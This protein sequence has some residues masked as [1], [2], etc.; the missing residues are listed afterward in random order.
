MEGIV[1]C[2]LYSLSCKLEL[3]PKTFNFDH[4]IP[5]IFHWYSLLQHLYLHLPNLRFECPWEGLTDFNPAALMEVLSVYLLRPFFIIQ[6]W[7]MVF[8]VLSIRAIETLNHDS[9]LPLVL[10]KNTQLGHEIHANGRLVMGAEEMIVQRWWNSGLCEITVENIMI[11][12]KWQTIGFD[13][14]M[15]MDRLI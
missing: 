2:A 5:L 15:R 6:L 3:R 7:N 1:P 9:F 10:C 12:C 4:W 8:D 14:K 11:W 13:R